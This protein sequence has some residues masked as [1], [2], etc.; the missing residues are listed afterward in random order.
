M[1]LKKVLR[2]RL[3]D[4]GAKVI[5]LL[6]QQTT[7]ENIHIL[8]VNMDTFMCYYLL[9]QTKFNTVNI[10]LKTLLPQYQKEYFLKD[11]IYMQ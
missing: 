2:R 6:S 3:V 10:Y 7:H 8:D 1:R 9:H 5:S 4:V 11:K